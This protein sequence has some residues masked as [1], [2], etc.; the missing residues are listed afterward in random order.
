M[1]QEDSNDYSM[2]TIMSL[3]FRNLLTQELSYGY[4]IAQDHFQWFDD[5]WQDRPTSAYEL[6]KRV[7]LEGTDERV[8][9]FLYFAIDSKQGVFADGDWFEPEVIQTLMSLR[10]DL[11]V[12]DSC[13]NLYPYDPEYCVCRKCRQLGF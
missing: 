9:D 5:P 6:L 8:V 3:E 12:C 11:V 13:T 2:F 4:R 7:A 10:E 1:R